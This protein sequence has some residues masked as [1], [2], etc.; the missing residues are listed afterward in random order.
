[1]SFYGWKRY[2][3]VAQRRKKAERAAAEASKAGS[4]LSPVR[5][6]RGAIAR[7]FWGRAWCDNLERYSDFANRLPRGRTYLRNGSVIDLK[8]KNGEVRARVMGRVL[9]RQRHRRCRSPRKQWQSISGD[10][11]GS[12]DSLVELLQGRAFQGS[13]GTNLQSRAPVSSRRRR[14]FDSVAAARTGLRCAST[15]RL[16][17]YGVGTRL[18]SQPELIFALR[19]VDPKDLVAQASVGLRRPTQRPHA[20]KVLD[21]AHLAEVFDIEIADVA[22]ARNPVTRRRESTTTNTKKTPARI[23]TGVAVGAARD[24]T[25][26]GMTEVAESA[27]ARKATI[28]KVPSKSSASPTVPANSKGKEA[29]LDGDPHMPTRKPAKKTSNAQNRIGKARLAAMIEEATVDAYGESEQTTGWYTM[30]EEHLALPFDTTLFGAVVKV[31]RLDLRGEN[32]IVAI[33]TRG[34]QRQPIRIL[35]LPLPSPGPEG[36]EWI[37][38]YRQ[39]LKG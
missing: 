15:S 19:R 38:A 31:V 9:R 4:G 17:S 28:A 29:L 20:G 35:D 36:A 39:W 11:A 23:G 22:S 30:L 32:D 16:C 37:E 24:A 1:M 25:A 2:V 27:A 33:C 6:S 12:I 13:D 34:R 14:R 7:T 21:D 18:D 5:S 26:T 10:C 8:I 3:P